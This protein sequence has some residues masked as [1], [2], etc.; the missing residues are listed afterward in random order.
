MM[1]HPPPFTFGLALVP[2]TLARNWA[3]VETLLNLTLESVQAQTDADFRVIIA[4]HDRP[5]TNMDSDPRLSFL[6]ADWL[7]QETGPNNDDSGR[8][9]HAINDYVLAQGGGLLMLVDA[10][11]WVDR[12]TVAA[13]RACIGPEHVG[14]LIQAGAILDFQSQRMAALPHPG[15]FPGAFHRLCGTSTVALLRP[16]EADPDRRDP[17]SILRSH[18]QWLEVAQE[19]GLQLASLAVSASYLI[20]TSENHSD[21]HGPHLDWRRTLTAAVNEQGRELDETLAAPFGLSAAS[22]RA[23]AARFFPVDPDA[24]VIT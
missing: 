13:A 20:N 17:F 21:L 11:D 12:H 7:V 5:R 19:H 9:K 4:G 8:K 6:P 16:D 10:D 2:R 3:L 15:I 18:H 23:A 1:R 14:G 22:V 24:C